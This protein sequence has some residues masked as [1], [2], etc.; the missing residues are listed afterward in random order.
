MEFSL[1]KE[2]WPDLIRDLN[3]WPSWCLSLGN[4]FWNRIFQDK[5]YPDMKLKIRIFFLDLGDKCSFLTNDSLS[6]RH[7]SLFVLWGPGTSIIQGMLALDWGAWRRL[8]TAVHGRCIA[9]KAPNKPG[10]NQYT[11]ILSSESLVGPICLL[12]LIFVDSKLAHFAVEV[13]FTGC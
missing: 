2:T 1:W 4:W 10:S 5:F 11:T 3:S 8:K 13:I 7:M 12:G 9:R 6:L